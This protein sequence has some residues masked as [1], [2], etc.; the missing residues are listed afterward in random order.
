M[1]Y[2]FE[3]KRPVIGQTSF[4]HPQAVLIGDV[5]LGEEC[6]VGAGAILRSDYGQVVIGNGCNI[7]ENCV[8]HS[9]PDSPAVIGD[10]VL[11]GHTAIV[12]GPCELKEGCVVGM[13]AIVSIGCTLEA[14]SMLAAGSILPPGRTIPAR[15][16]AVGNP[17]R[18]ARDVDEQTA[19]INRIAVQFYRELAGR[20]L[21]GLKLIED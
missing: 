13:G 14:D 17:A 7:Q 15:K 16:L 8:V 12:H 3:G 1:L 10:N 6:Y 20:C 2:E 11:V 9:Q 4:V 18:V 19:A 21:R 5:I